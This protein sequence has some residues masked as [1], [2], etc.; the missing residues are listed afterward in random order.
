[1]VMWPL[2]HRFCTRV[3]WLGVVAPVCFGSLGTVRDRVRGASDASHGATLRHSPQVIRCFLKIVEDDLRLDE[4]IQ[5]PLDDGT[6]KD[7]DYAECHTTDVSQLV[8][9]INELAREVMV[10]CYGVGAISECGIETIKKAVI[11]S[12]GRDAA[13]PSQGH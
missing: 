12:A 13:P 8:A 11:T 1:M 6:L 3:L 5:Q 7:Y 9:G 2:Q 10:H 4:L